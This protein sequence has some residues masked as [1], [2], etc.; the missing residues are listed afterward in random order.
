MT[1]SLLRG[2]PRPARQGEAPSPFGF[3]RG[4]AVHVA[5]RADP[6][7]AETRVG[8][9]R[10]GGTLSQRPAPC[11]RPPTSANDRVPNC[12]VPTVIGYDCFTSRAEIPRGQSHEKIII[13]RPLR[14]PYKKPRR[15]RLRPRSGAQAFT[16]SRR[17]ALNRASSDLPSSARRGHCPAHLSGMTPDPVIREAIGPFE[18]S[19]PALFGFGR[20]LTECLR[21]ELISG[22][23]G[24]R[25]RR[26]RRAVFCRE[27]HVSRG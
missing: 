18:T 25:C 16:N 22:L 26:Q 21:R 19:Q 27:R 17:S 13:R 5:I 12:A 9:V 3:R 1:T 23:P 11:H 20:D 7:A 24:F 14:P 4:G 2:D 10:V 6:D 8:I 15:S